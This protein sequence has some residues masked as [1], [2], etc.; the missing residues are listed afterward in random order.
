MK[1]PHIS[2]SIF[3]IAQHILQLATCN[4]QFIILLLLWVLFFWRFFTPW[5]ADRVMFPEGDFTHHYYVYRSFAYDELR[6]GRFPLW[7]PGVFSGYPFQ[8]D[9]QSALFYPPAMLV[10][11]FCLMLGLLHFPLMALEAEA[12]LHILA[13]SFFTYI[14]LHDLLSHHT[15]PR[16]NATIPRHSQDVYPPLTSPPL[17][18]KERGRGHPSPSSEPECAVSTPPKPAARPSLA[19]LPTCKLTNSQARQLA[20]LLGAVVF[21]YGGYLTSYPPLQIAILE[22]V[23]WLPLALWATRRLLLRGSRIYLVLLSLAWAMSILAGNPQAYIHVI[24]A[25]VGYYLYVWILEAGN[26]NTKDTK[27]TKGANTKGAK[28]T[29]WKVGLKLVG[30]LGLATGICAVQLLPSL[31]YARLSTR[32]SIPFSEAGTGFPPGDILQIVLPGL[33]SLWQPLYVGLLPL[34]LALVAVV[35]MGRRRPPARGSMRI[36]GVHFS[37]GAEESHG[38]PASA[39]DFLAEARRPSAIHP[40]MEMHPITGRTEHEPWFWVGLAVIALVFSFGANVFG[41]DLA[42]LTWPGY[43]L[44]RSQERHAFLVSFALAVLAAQGMYALLTPWRRC[45]RRWAMGVAR[46]LRQALGIGFLLLLVVQGL[47]RWG[48]YQGAQEFRDK[49]GL[50]WLVLLFLNGIWHLWVYLPRRRSRVAMLALAL[51]VF[52]LFSFNRPLDQTR[53]HALFPVTPLLE[54]ILTDKQTSASSVP[55]VTYTTQFRVQ[56]DWRLPGH[57]LPMHSIPEVGGIASIKPARYHRFLQQ[58]PEALRWR[59]LDVRYVITWRG[60]L[61][62]REGTPVEA[63][64]IYHEGEGKE[65]TYL[66]RL[67]E[68]YPHAWVVHEARVV[69]GEEA[70]FATLRDPAFDPDREAVVEQTLPLGLAPATGEETVEMVEYTPQRVVLRVHLTAPGL[71][72]LSDA[73][74][75]GWRAR[76]DGRGMPLLRADGALR[77]VTVEAGEHRIEMVYQPRSLTVGAAISGVTILLTLTWVMARRRR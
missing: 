47:S 35:M 29:N 16:D 1:K 65:A 32:S 12:A 64:M 42:Y 49:L 48:P 51:V 21:A 33:V 8:A 10:M 39:G 72:V 4:W 75:P 9:P 44:T 56:D 57:T 3:R 71:V 27:D 58:V 6:A 41:F 45:E 63:E 76:V 36:T 73:H 59:L 68:D 53:P 70:V 24:Y 38:G 2:H 74:F 77:A 52:D 15:V 26:T 40:K 67:T 18:G 19:S 13:A 50:S 17:G 23:I 7:W 30:A 69:N 60:S 28:G 66:Y 31:E 55:S 62:T 61:V 22:G 34:L 43:K 5:E 20:S 11:L 54:H 25:T 37:S 46:F 14:F